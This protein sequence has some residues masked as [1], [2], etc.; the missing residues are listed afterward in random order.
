MLGHHRAMKLLLS[1]ATLLTLGAAAPAQPTGLSAELILPAALPRTAALPVSFVL[2]NDRATSFEGGVSEC[3][4]NYRLLD[5]TTGRQ[6]WQFRSPGMAGKT[7]LGPQVRLLPQSAG[8]IYRQTLY[9]GASATQAPARLKPGAYTLIGSLEIT[10]KTPAFKA[11][12]L[13]TKPA[14]FDIP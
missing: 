8:E 13:T 10:G 9:V 2:R 11:M 3:S 14:H 5:R 7:V 6:L 4:V 1:S 12:T